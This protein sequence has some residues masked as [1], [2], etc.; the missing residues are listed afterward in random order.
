MYFGEHYYT[1]DDELEREYDEYM[2]RK[3][4]EYMERM[5]C[6]EME[7]EAENW[8]Y[9]NVILPEYFDALEMENFSG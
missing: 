9:E 5:Y 6:E 4:D 7:L 8:A 2:E 3:Y 1:E